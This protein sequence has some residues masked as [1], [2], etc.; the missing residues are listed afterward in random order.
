[1]HL[2][3]LKLPQ[4]AC[5]QIRATDP[6]QCHKENM[7][8]NILEQDRQRGLESSIRL[9]KGNWFTSEW[10]CCRTNP[11]K[12]LQSVTLSSRTGSSS[13]QQSSFHL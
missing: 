6:V 8:L 11:N 10:Q 4:F 7:V 12:L 9:G 3:V 5:S 1:M 2:Y 13:R